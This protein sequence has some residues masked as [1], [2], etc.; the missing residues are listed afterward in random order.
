MSQ[1]SSDELKLN[2]SLLILKLS[3][4]LDTAEKAQILNVL[5]RTP[6]KSVETLLLLGTILARPI[7]TELIR[8]GLASPTT[9]RDL[10]D[11]L[12]KVKHLLP[13]LQLP[14]L[15]GSNALQCRSFFG[16]Q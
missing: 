1:K 12:G 13:E 15:H 10:S 5:V 16:G 7:V 11:V 14:S 2:A 3:E 6:D 4:R 8:D 9:A